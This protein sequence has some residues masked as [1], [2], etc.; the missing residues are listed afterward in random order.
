MRV[1]LLKASFG[2]R[3]K[4]GGK[5]E[6]RKG[7]KKVKQRSRSLRGHCLENPLKSRNGSKENERIFSCVWGRVNI[8]VGRGEKGR[9]G[10]ERE[11]GERKEVRRKE[12]GCG[13]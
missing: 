2:E 5:A 12:K 3:M 13:S 6:E 10:R 7:K 1:E 8:F 4:V 11:E 9:A